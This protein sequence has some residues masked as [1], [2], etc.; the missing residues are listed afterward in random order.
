ML[1]AL[2]AVSMFGTESALVLMF[3]NWFKE[4]RDSK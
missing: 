3:A 4:E 2:A 1:S